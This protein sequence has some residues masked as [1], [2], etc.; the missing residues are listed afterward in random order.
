MISI[1]SVILDLTKQYEEIFYES[2]IETTTLVSE[3]ILIKND[4]PSNFYEE[5]T[6]R[7][8]KFKKYGN[9]EQAA[10]FTCGDQHG[11]GLNIAIE[12]SINEIVYLCD[13]DLFFMSAADEFFYNLKQT[14]SLN[15]V[16]CSHHSATELAGTFFP[17]H[18]NVM[19]DKNNLPMDIDFLKED[20][21]IPGRYLMSEAGVSHKKIYPNPNGNFD[22]ASGLWLWAHKNNWKW[23]SFQSTDAHC[24]TTKFYRGNGNV[25]INKLQ[26][27]K[28]IYHAV[29]GSIEK[30]KWEP[31]RAAY[32]EWKNNED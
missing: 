29:S 27:Q 23:L 18:G 12:K 22:T 5:W 14:Y 15:A 21:K 6:K 30:E 26:I 32:Q 10:R 31:Y 8:I 13:P 7:G 11:L 2:I 16:G 4:A 25:K 3:V 20:L 24:Y 1:C 19:I 28:L 9:S 17:W